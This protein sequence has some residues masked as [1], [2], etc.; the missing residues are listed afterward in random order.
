MERKTIV[1]I[2]LG[3]LVISLGVILL[4]PRGMDNT[5]VGEQEAQ[6]V[7]IPTG[8]TVGNEIILTRQFFSPDAMTLKRGDSLMLEFTSIGVE[9][10]ISAP[11]IGVTRTLGADAVASI[12]TEPLAAG[13]ITIYCTSGCDADVSMTVTIE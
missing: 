1:F 12:T 9:R 4:V 13:T 10:S 8:R 3:A 5:P 6:E 7:I 2:I 11:S